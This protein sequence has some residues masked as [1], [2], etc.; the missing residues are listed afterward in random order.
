MT[1]PEITMIARATFAEVHQLVSQ[2]RYDEA[3]D[4]I[5]RAIAASVDPE[6]VPGVPAEAHLSPE[7]RSVVL[8]L[9]QHQEAIHTIVDTDEHTPRPARPAISRV[10]Q[11][12]IARLVVLDTRLEALK[13]RK[14]PTGDAARAADHTDKP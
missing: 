12:A 11:R 7:T 5:K 10:I 4:V 14:S 9:R 2:R 13:R 1:G 8:A 6:T 3:E